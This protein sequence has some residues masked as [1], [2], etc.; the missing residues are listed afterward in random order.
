MWDEPGPEEDSYLAW[1]GRYETEDEPSGF[2]M[3]AS[4]GSACEKTPG[5]DLGEYKDAAAVKE[6]ESRDMV[7]TCDTL[8]VSHSP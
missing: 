5:S 7:E 8:V 6:E 2:K 1:D 4:T 3:T